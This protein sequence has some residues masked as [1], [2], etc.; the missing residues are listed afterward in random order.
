M[1]VKKLIS[2]RWLLI[3]ILGASAGYGVALYLQSQSVETK[4]IQ[5][6]V[7]VI[8]THEPPSYQTASTQPGFISQQSEPLSKSESSYLLLIREAVS[9]QEF[10]KAFDLLAEAQQRFGTSAPRLVLL[11]E[12][13]QQ[14]E[15]FKQA[16]A[17]LHQALEVDPTLTAQIYLMIRQVVTALINQQTDALSFNEKVQILSQEIIN[18]PGFANYHML[19][20][21]LYYRHEN[22]P[23]AITNLEYALQLDHTQRATLQPLIDA[24]KQRLEHPGLVELPISSHGRAINV[25][26]RLNNAPQRFH[27]ILDTGASFTAISMK[28]AQQLGITISA[29]HPTVQI[30]TANGLIQ[31]PM[32]TLNAVNLQGALVEQVSAVVLDELNGFDGLLG[33]SFL[34]HFNIDINQDEGKLLLL[35]NPTDL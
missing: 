24:A 9:N 21:R 33:L 32:V 7:P 14:R 13:H 31:A 1:Q 18:D 29:D 17:A 25:D 5:P 20:G 16:R 26:V 22:Y 19:L 2:L 8:G 6:T 3:F 28:V 11:A 35:K 23:D 12:L 34:S 30:S 15:N 27:F 4:I 10:N